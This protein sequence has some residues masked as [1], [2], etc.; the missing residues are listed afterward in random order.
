M[1]LYLWPPPHARTRTHA[2]E[3]KQRRSWCQR[4]NAFVCCFDLFERKKIICYREYKI[5]K[6]KETLRK[7]KTN[8]ANIENEYPLDRFLFL[9]SSL[10]SISFYSH[11]Q[12]FV[13]ADTCP[14][15]D[16]NRITNYCESC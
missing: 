3:R 15:K 9:Y 12:A 14:N 6:E 2:H 7:I 16:T 8:L 10:F 11:T 4:A 5:F 1:I 13:I